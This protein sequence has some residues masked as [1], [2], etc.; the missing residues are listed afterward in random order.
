M[1]PRGQRKILFISHESSLTGAPVLL[2]NL[3]R[4]LKKRNVFDFEILLVRGG[5]IEVDFKSL[6]K[7]D[8]LKDKS[9]SAEKRFLYRIRNYVLYLWKLK[10]WRNCT[11]NFD[12]IFS[13]TVT[14]GRLLNKINVHHL[15]VIIYVHELESIIRTYKP[16]ARL[17]LADKIAVPSGAVSDNLVQ[18]HSVPREKIFKLNY[19]F[20]FIAAQQTKETARVELI[21]R[22]SIEGKFFVVSMGTATLRKGFDLFMEVC[23]LLKHDTEIFFIWL[24]DFVDQEMK[25]RFK[26]YTER[27]GLSKKIMVTG[28]LPY[29]FSNLLPFD[30]FLLTSREDPYPLVVIEAAFNKLPAIS[31]ESGGITE[32]ISTDAGWTIPDFSVNLMA[33]KIVELKQNPSRVSEVGDAAFEKAKRLHAN[34]ETIIL[35]LST[36]LNEV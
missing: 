36:L 1:S 2:M 33:E 27:N 23:N 15:P 11:K 5:A 34:E 25:K 18:N 7:T 6:T 22:Y 8:V 24:G 12:I 30:L 9:Y 35:Q 19:F 28:F 4:L 14:N 17:S 26:E 13:N 20:P 21:K 10:K 32:F 29:S 3:L 16:D 31:F